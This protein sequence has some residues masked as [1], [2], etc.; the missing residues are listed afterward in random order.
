M[1]SL[2]AHI[3]VQAAAASFDRRDD[4]RGLRS[5]A[6]ELNGVLTAK[7]EQGLRLPD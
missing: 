3:K 5:C 7:P 2:R 1:R 6:L 4:W